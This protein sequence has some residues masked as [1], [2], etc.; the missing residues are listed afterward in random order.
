MGGTVAYG[1]PLSTHDRNTH[2]LKRELEY[3]AIGIRL[4][5]VI[6]D[7]VKRVDVSGST[8]Y[9]CY[10]DLIQG[11]N[12]ELTNNTE[13]SFNAYFEKMLDGMELWADACEE[14]L[15]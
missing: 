10:R 3:E 6:V 13:Y 7:A 5:E 4:N 15:E 2:N 9:E 1:T 11:L 12:S 14:V 8:Y